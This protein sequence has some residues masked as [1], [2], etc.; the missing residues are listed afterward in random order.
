MKNDVFGRGLESRPTMKDAHSP[1]GQE[2]Y[3]PPSMADLPDCPVCKYGTPYPHKKD[4]RTHQVLSYRC[5]DCKA[6]L[7]PEQ[8]K[9]P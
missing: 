5:I 7:K 8:V 4:E 2:F 6:I 1:A 9:R 3:A